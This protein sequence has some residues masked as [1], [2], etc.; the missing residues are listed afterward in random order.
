GHSDVGGL[1]GAVGAHGRRDA[2]AAHADEVRHG[3]AVAGI[4]AHVMTVR[5]TCPPREGFLSAAR[6]A[7]TTRRHPVR[8]GTADA[9]A[10]PTPPTPGR[11][12]GCVAAACARDAPTR[13]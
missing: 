11:P 5:L 4:D 13:G 10:G 6:R 12:P 8:P 7:P 2:R 3:G 1:R 9:V